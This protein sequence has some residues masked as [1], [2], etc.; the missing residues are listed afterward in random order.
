[1]DLLPSILTHLAIQQLAVCLRVNWDFFEIAGKFLYSREMSFDSFTR[2]PTIFAGITSRRRGLTGREVI[3]SRTKS[4]LLGH[5]K[6]LDYYGHERSFCKHIRGA[7]NLLPNL[8]TLV[9]YIEP[10]LPRYHWD[11]P[12]LT[13][14]SPRHIQIKEIPSIQAHGSTIPLDELFGHSATRVTLCAYGCLLRT[15]RIGHPVISISWPRS[16]T[17]LDIICRRSSLWNAA[18]YGAESEE[19]SWYP[20]ILFTEVDE[21]VDSLLRLLFTAEHLRAKVRIEGY[22]R[23]FHGYGNPVDEVALRERFGTGLVQGYK[24]G[25]LER[26]IAVE[27]AERR[28]RE[29]EY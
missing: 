24:K 25:L 10:A 5:L 8:E 1:M 7:D 17:H 4:M 22:G 12:I 11:C 2:R 18:P 3:I 14:L 20:S 16:L 28:S 15:S 19:E 26:G 21:A 29:L 9:L 6:C 23:R 13:G 27:A